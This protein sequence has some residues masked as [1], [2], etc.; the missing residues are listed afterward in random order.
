MAGVL[1][2]L[3]RPV[4]WAQ[5]GVIICAYCCYKALDNYSL[6]GVEVLGLDEV[7]AA[8]L[9]SYGAYARPVAALAAGI[10][11]DRFDA[12]RAL[13][14]TFLLLLLVY[15]LLATLTPTTAGLLPIYGSL[16]VSMFAVFALRGI[17]FALLEETRTPR[18][19]TGAAVGAISFV[20]FTPEIFFASIAGR[21][22]DADPGIGGHLD[23]FRFL[24][25]IAAAGTV[26][27]VTLLWLKRRGN[28]P[29]AQ[30][31]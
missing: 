31:C 17:Y 12:S 23:Y 27:V 16:L 24:G 20:G 25:A 28:E 21:I 9:T 18:N 29:G 30:D 3:R 5:A 22:L 15:A 11:A 2:V 10:I 4:I 14:V 7:Q 6:Y 19:V 26:I 1:Q 13:G 8:G